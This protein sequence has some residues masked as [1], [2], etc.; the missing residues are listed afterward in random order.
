[1]AVTGNIA[2][3]KTIAL[4][5]VGALLMYLPLMDHATPEILTAG[6]WRMFIF[7]VLAPVGAILA[8]LKST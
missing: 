2:A 5:I 1:M 8:E 7:G 6:F 4:G 3:E